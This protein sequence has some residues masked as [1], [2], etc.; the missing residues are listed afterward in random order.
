MVIYLHVTRMP[1]R[2]HAPPLSVAFASLAALC[3]LCRFG[4]AV[5]LPEGSLL[6]GGGSAVKGQVSELPWAAGGGNASCGEC[7][8]VVDAIHTCCSNGKPFS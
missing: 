8:E 5:P 6:G 7:I 4:V 1:P 2:A 3:A